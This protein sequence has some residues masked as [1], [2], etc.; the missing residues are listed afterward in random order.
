MADKFTPPSIDW[1]SSGDVHKRFKRFRQKCEYLFKGP[2]MVFN[3]KII[4]GISL[5][6]EKVLDVL[7][8]YTKPQRNQILS[9]Y[10]LRCLK[11][12]DMSLEEFIIKACLLVGD[13]GCQEAVQQETLRDT[14]VFQ[15]KFDNVKVQENR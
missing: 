13:S 12:C 14:L 2:K 1:T 9:R 11:Q 8:N 3:R 7:D 4:L 6:N 15:L 10:Q 5:Q